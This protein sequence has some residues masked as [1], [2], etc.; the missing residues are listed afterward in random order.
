MHTVNKAVKALLI[1]S[2]PIKQKYMVTHAEYLNNDP[3]KCPWIGIYRGDSDYEPRSISSHSS[4]KKWRAQPS[5]DI[6][7]QASS[8]RSGAD[9]EEKLEEYIAEV[10]DIILS[11]PKL[12]GTVS[13]ITGFNI[14]YSFNEEASE[15]VY[16]N[17]ATITVNVEART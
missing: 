4:G 8:G 9:A 16:F 17:M 11:N 10:M 14:V 7:I 2:L 6:K 13:T 3:D 12:S 1:D 15:S 5:I